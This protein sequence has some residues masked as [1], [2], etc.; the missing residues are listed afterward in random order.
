MVGA[1]FGLGTGMVF[2]GWGVAF[3][4]AGELLRADLITFDQT[5]KAAL[6]LLF[7]AAGVGQTLGLMSDASKI[8]AGTRSTYAVLDRP[9]RID[10]GAGRGQRPQQLRG[11]VELRDVHFTYPSRAEAP[12]FRGLSLR[13]EAGQTVG[14]VGASGSGK[15]TVLVG[16]GGPAPVAADSPTT[17]PRR[18]CRCWSASTSPPP[19]RCSSTACPSRTWTWP[20]CARTSAWWA[21][22]PCCSTPPSR[23]WAGP[24]AARARACTPL[25]RTV[26]A[27][28]LLVALPQN[29]RYGKLDATMDEVKEAARLANAH[30]FIEQMPEGYDTVVGVGGSRL[31]GGQ[32]RR[33]LY[34]RSLV[35]DAPR[36][37]H[38]PC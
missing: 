15:S 8:R 12:I 14:V 7:A 22:S 25:S 26:P 38:T 20:G 17:S 9:S 11:E 5:L 13:V 6:A 28:G 31:S 18:W 1:S 32:V 33:R 21:R 36:E 16:R 4:A 19:G 37:A 27:V 34:A 2:L 3:I 10:A 29:I 23:R 35:P 24:R 30:D